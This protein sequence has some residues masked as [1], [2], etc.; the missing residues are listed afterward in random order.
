MNCYLKY[1]LA[2]KERRESVAD[3]AG[4]TIYKLEYFSSRYLSIFYSTKESNFYLKTK[5][6]SYKKI[7]YNLKKHLILYFTKFFDT[8]GPT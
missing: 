8:T 6:E 3:N 7:Q 1:V 2:A 5:G 4:Y